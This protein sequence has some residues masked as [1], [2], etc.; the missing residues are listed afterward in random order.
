MAYNNA[1]KPK[2]DAHQQIT[3][4]IIAQLEKVNASD[5]QCPW[6]RASGQFGAPTNGVTNATYRGINWLLLGLATEETNCSVFATYKQWQS[7]GRQVAKG[8]TGYPVTFFKKLEVPADAADADNTDTRHIPMIRLSTVFAESQLTDYQA[9]EAQPERPSLVEVSAA[10][11]EAV[12]NL[13][14]VIK[15]DNLNAAF[16]RSADDFINMPPQNAFKASKT[17]SATENYYSTLLH[18]LTHWTGHGTRCDRPLRNAFG[19]KAYAK[20]ELVAELGAAFLCQQFGIS[21]ELRE[22]HAQYLKSWLECLRGDK[23]FIFNAASLAQ[24]A[25]D[26]INANSISQAIAA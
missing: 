19:S 17:S 8:S 12:A 11:E 13:G 7:R 26:Y 25:V 23:K 10:V 24:K 14:A 5:W 4:K 3:D 22:D 1:N 18:E 21:A 15:Q 2:V 16:Y 6:H 9:P 20:E